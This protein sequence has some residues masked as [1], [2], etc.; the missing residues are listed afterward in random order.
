MR[1]TYADVD[2]MLHDNLAQSSS[3][4]D[5][6]GTL[7]DALAT[8][9]EPS[10]LIDIIQSV[11]EDPAIAAACAARSFLHPLGFSKITLI[12]APGLY[13]LRLHAWWP[14]TTAKYEHVHNHRFSFSSVIVCGGYEMRIF[15]P[16][17]T[18]QAMTE[19]HEE[20]SAQHGWR[21]RRVGD[22]YL[23]TVSTHRLHARSSYA[24]P[25][26]ALHQVMAD[27]AAPCVTLFLQTVMTETATRVFTPAG[28][29]PPTQIPKQPFEPAVYRRQLELL[30]AELSTRP[31][32]TD[33]DAYV[34]ST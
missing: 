29:E 13:T 1:M 5:C 24:L 2:R 32:P 28:G 6:P 12:D 7:L 25:T 9:A 18:G 11:Y 23:R 33:T 10:Q 19:Y 30:L 4:R 26:H 15:E 22:A 14:T 8:L 3:H 17:E 34:S 21:L 31:Y 20:V 16:A 27:P